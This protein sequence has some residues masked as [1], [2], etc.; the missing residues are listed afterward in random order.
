MAVQQGGLC[1]V[2][3]RI[4]AMQPNLKQLVLDNCGLDDAALD[5][6]QQLLTVHSVDG[7]ASISLWN[8]KFSPARRAAWRAALQGHHSLLQIDM[9]EPIINTQLVTPHRQRVTA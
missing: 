5:A 8:N 3:I 1:Q 4:V 6:M 7:L 2:L 9:P